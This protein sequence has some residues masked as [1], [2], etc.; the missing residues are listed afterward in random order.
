MKCNQLFLTISRLWLNDE[1]MD[2]LICCLIGFNV[3]TP[4][5]GV[6]GVRMPLKSRRRRLK[7]G[8]VESS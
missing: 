8:V 2:A 3:V 4:L 1:R 5:A 7:L 6:E